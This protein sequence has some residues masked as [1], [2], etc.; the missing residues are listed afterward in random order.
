MIGRMNGR[1][2]GPLMLTQYR[3]Y[4]AGPAAH[5]PSASERRPDEGFDTNEGSRVSNAHS[6]EGNQRWLQ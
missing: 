1:S 2:Y 5:S 6:R 3:H 4:D